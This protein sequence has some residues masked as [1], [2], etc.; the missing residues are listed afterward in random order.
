MT[1]G[2]EPLEKL[3]AY[4]VEL[5]AEEECLKKIIANI[6]AQTHALQVSISKYILSSACYSSRAKNTCL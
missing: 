4:Q 5:V 2:K 1:N 6:N 3:L